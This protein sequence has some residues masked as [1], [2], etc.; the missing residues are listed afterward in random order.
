[1]TNNQGILT[2][3]H[4]T[5]DDLLKYHR[6]LLSEERISQIENHLKHCEFCSDAITGI[7]QMIDAKR[8]YSITHELKLR[9]KKRLF[10]KKK[11]FSRF[12][13]LTLFLVFFIISLIIFLAFYFLIIR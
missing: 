12:D 3:S 4:L 7:E 5:S 9:M 10:Q 11:I 8:I 6:R 1:M 2:S 13:L